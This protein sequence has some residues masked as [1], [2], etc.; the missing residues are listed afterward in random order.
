MPHAARQEQ[1]PRRYDLDWL[2]VLVI[3]FVFVYHVGLIFQGT[4][5]I[6][7][8]VTS[9]HLGKILGL[10]AFLRM[11]LLFF[12]AGAGTWFLFRR[13]NGGTFLRDRVLRLGVPLI[14]GMLVLLPVQEYFL[15]Q[16]HGEPAQS[17]LSVW[18]D[19]LGEAVLALNNH[20]S[21]LWFIA[22]LLVFSVVAAPLFLFLRRPAGAR[23]LERGLSSVNG[24]AL[25]GILAVP[26]ALAQWSLSWRWPGGWAFTDD[27]ARVAV[28]FLLFVYGYALFG[29]NQFWRAVDQHKGSAAAGGI[30]CLASIIGLI[31]V[32]GEDNQRLLSP[33]YS[34][35]A[36]LTALNGWLWIVGSLGYAR[37][38]L[39]FENGLLRYFRD[40]GY[41]FY[42]L[43]QPIL[44]AI[45][46]LVIPL[47]LNPIVKFMIIGLVGF[48]LTLAAYELLVRRWQ[49]MRFAFGLKT[50]IVVSDLSLLRRI[51]RRKRM[52]PEELVLDGQPQD[53]R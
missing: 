8:D 30:L 43:H 25:L 16:H 26:L 53:P 44:I 49:I 39:S 21:H 34:A 40:M 42:V 15:R 41:P 35:L 5:V 1:I 4:W 7:N 36:A 10:S 33:S 19:F 31:L 28:F 22:Y 24:S 9:W 47:P 50:N 20:W 48:T 12:I 3:L 46:V 2:R 6:S 37:Q 52:G 18:G 23:L 11:P 29:S 13:R 27:W 51:G 38:F 32:F 45:G 17:L 14:V